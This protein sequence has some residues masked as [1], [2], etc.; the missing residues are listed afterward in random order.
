MLQTP[1]GEMSCTPGRSRQWSRS[2]SCFCLGAHTIAQVPAPFWSKA[3]NVLAKHSQ[4]IAALLYVCMYIPQ[5]APAAV[6]KSRRNFSDG[7]SPG[8]ALWWAATQQAS[9]LAAACAGASNTY[10]LKLMRNSTSARL[11]LN[12]REQRNVVLGG[13]Y[14][15][16]P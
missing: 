13:C 1:L 14:R 8:S 15:T 2:G 9:D 10:L 12:C 16:A 11:K 4:Q 7:L 6:S 3:L 5:A